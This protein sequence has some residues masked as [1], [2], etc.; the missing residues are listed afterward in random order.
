MGVVVPSAGPPPG[1]GTGARP[2]RRLWDGPG[3]GSAAL[4]PDAGVTAVTA[5]REAAGALQGPAPRRARA[6][7]AVV[8][9]GRA[10]RP[11][12]PRGTRGWGAARAGAAPTLLAEN[13]AGQP[14][15]SV[16]C[17]SREPPQSSTARPKAWHRR[18]SPSGV[19]LGTWD[20]RHLLRH[21]WLTHGHGLF[22]ATNSPWV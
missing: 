5:A 8:S 9:C 19:G 20:R 4:G 11:R 14:S 1:E 12:R 6:Q 2:P 13:F 17:A 10:A 22:R 7:P 15:G 3:T 21:L 16:L 18:R